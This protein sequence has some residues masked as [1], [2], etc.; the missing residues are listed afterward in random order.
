MRSVFSSSRNISEKAGI[1]EREYYACKTKDNIR[2]LIL[3]ASIFRLFRCRDS[4]L[5]LDP[6]RVSI[7]RI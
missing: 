5:S 2:M 6:S 4:V 7:D 1:R 3:Y